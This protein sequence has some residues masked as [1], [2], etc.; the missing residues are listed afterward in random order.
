MMEGF[1]PPPYGHQG[2]EEVI[3][4]SSPLGAHTRVCA[5]REEDMIDI[6]IHGMHGITCGARKDGSRA[7]LWDD[8]TVQ[9]FKA[10]EFNDLMISVEVTEMLA[11]C[12]A[13]LGA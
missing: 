8:N 1:G 2:G 13:M 6:N 4:T 7:V 3:V 11:E 5:G 10:T 9:W 12:N